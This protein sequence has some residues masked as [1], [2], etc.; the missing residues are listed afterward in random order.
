MKKKKSLLTKRLYFAIAVLTLLIAAGIVTTAFTLPTPGSPTHSTLFTDL[1]VSMIGSTG[2]VTIDSSVLATKN[3]TATGGGTGFM[4]MLGTNTEGVY[5]KSST[6]SEGRLGYGT[7][8]VYTPN[9]LYAGSVT[10][11]ALSASSVSTGTLSL[12]GAMSASSY[13]TTGSAAIGVSA[14]NTNGITAQLASNTGYG[15]YTP[16]GVYAG[17][18]AGGA[19]YGSSISTGSISATYISSSGNIDAAAGIQAKA[20][21]SSGNI[22]AEGGSVYARDGFSTPS[23][24]GWTGCI[25]DATNKKVCF[26]NGIVTSVS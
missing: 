19:F 18:Y 17:Y 14:S 20:F 5:G 24:A 22:R 10:T 7:W 15:V 16:Y 1:I 3:I 4:G 25:T 26:S 13:T 8:G 11:G 12:S 6:G 9:A 21:T 23:G 2:K